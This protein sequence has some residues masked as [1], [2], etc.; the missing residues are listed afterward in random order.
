MGQSLMVGENRWITIDRKFVDFGTPAKM[1]NVGGHVIEIASAV[2][3]KPEILQRGSEFFHSNLEPVTD[4]ED[5][6][7]LPEPYRGQALKFIASRAKST[8]PLKPVKGKTTEEGAPIPPQRGRS[9]RGQTL[10]VETPEQAERVFVGAGGPPADE[11]EAPAR[12]RG[13]R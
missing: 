1:G 9:I 13:A 10:R 2:A 5:V 4:P 7:Y 3:A 12:G 8:K 6:S 11:D